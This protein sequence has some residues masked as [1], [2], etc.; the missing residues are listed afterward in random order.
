MTPCP[1]CSTLVPKHV[2]PSCGATVT[3]SSRSTAAMAL[4]GLGLLTGCPPDEPPVTALYGAA[5]VDEDGDGYP[6]DTDCDDT[7]A[8]IHPDAV[9]E[10]GDGVDSN[11]DGD[12]D[13]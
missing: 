8:D 10:P 7:D 12:D 4:L 3:R 6:T 9:E 13:T 2:C 1:H 5:A 11:C